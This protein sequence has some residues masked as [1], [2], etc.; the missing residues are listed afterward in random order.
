MESVAEFLRALPLFKSF[1][2]TDLSVLIEKSRLEVFGPQETIIHY[3]QSGSFL[4]IILEG[5]AEAV[6]AGNG[7]KPERLGLINRGDFL[8]EISLITGEPTVADVVALERC[9]LLLIPQ[10]VFYESLVVNPKAL[11]VIAKTITERLRRREGDKAAQMRVE[12]AWQNTP[13][14]YG[15]ELTTFTSPGSIPMPCLAQGTS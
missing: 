15:L 4:G 11:R 12:D 10:E 5:Q 2:P 13:D 6:V 8:G 7:D 9:E 3:G 1:S 14:P